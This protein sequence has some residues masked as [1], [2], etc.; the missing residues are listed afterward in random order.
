MNWI[1]LEGEKKVAL[2]V[3]EFPDVHIQRKEALWLKQP[4]V[5]Y[6]QCRPNR[7]SPLKSVVVVDALE[8]FRGT[9]TG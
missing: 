3:E 4:G 6:M 5:E 9:S 2:N 8:C 1:Y 7:G